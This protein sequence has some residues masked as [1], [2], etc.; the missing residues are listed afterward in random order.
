M[1]PGRHVSYPAPS[2]EN[3]ATW[4]EVA[5]KACASIAE[6]S[7]GFVQCSDLAP[8]LIAQIGKDTQGELLIGECT[9]TTLTCCLAWSSSL[10]CSACL[11]RAS[12]SVASMALVTSS[13]RTRSR[14]RWRNVSSSRSFSTACARSE[15]RTL[16]RVGVGLGTGV[17]IL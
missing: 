17:S 1:V 12:R 3:T 6:Q 2:L 4:R 13:W 10:A 5:E 9:T 14:P 16:Q 8:P 11:A 15:R 7:R